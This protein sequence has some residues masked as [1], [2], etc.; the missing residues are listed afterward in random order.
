MGVA[1]GLDWI[2]RYWGKARPRNDQGPDWHPLAYHSLDVAAAMGAMLDARPAWLATVAT[3]CK[4]DPEEARLR[5]ILVAALHDLGKFADNFQQKA[6]A[7]RALLQPTAGLAD[8]NRGHGEIGAELWQAIP[9]A[10]KVSA[11]SAWAFAAFA[12][13]GAP[14][15][16]SDSFADAASEVSVRDA[17]AFTAAMIDLIGAPNQQRARGGEWLVAGL[18]TLADWIGSNQT[19][20]P[21]APPNQALTAYWAYSQERAR[22]AVAD[23]RLVEALPSSSFGLTSILGESAKPSPLQKW[24]EQQTPSSSPQLYIIE[25]LTG[26]GKS[27]A[28]IILAHRLIAAGAAEGLFWAL[29]T[30][31]TANGLYGRLE[32]SYTAL[33]AQGEHPSLVLA[34]GARDIHDGFQASIGRERDAAYGE[35]PHDEQDISAE[36][37]CAAFVA[38]DRKKSFLAEVGVGTID[39]ALLAVLPVRHQSLRLAA[40]SRRVLII[41]EAH[42]YDPYMATELEGLL[43]FQAFNGGSAIVMSATLSMKNRAKLIE[44]CARGLGEAATNQAFPL[45]THVCAGT[46]SEVPQSPARGTQRDL[47]VQRFETPEAVIDALLEKAGQ[48]ACGVYVRNT[49]ADAMQA[50]EALKS[51][52]PEGVH[53]E[54]FHARYAICDRKTVENSTL[55]RFGPNSRPEDRRARILVAT[56]VVEQSLDLDFD[57]MATD[58]CP[59][60][61]IIQRAGRLHRHGHRPPRPAPVLWVVGPEARMDVEA[62]WYARPFPIAKYVYPDVGQLWRTMTLLTAQGGLNFKTGS[63]RDFIEPVFGHQAMDIPTSLMAASDGAEVK[64]MTERSLGHMNLLKFNRFDRQGG[65][66]DSDVRTPTRLGEDTMTLRLARWQ[67]GDLIPWCSSAEG[68]RAWRLSEISVPRRWLEKP[69]YPSEAA[70]KTVRT[71][72]SQWPDRY[73]APLVLVLEPSEEAEIWVGA[74]YDRNERRVDVRYSARFGLE[75]G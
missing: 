31:A 32:R 48:G 71:V 27:E 28:A 1:D 47:P 39:Q 61:L 60:D 21:Y 54:L 49:V 74:W 26:A 43:R 69:I 30:M 8:C 57:Y 59:M 55:A 10:Q 18:V 51:A 46:V 7:L 11:L 33:F 38:E 19:W 14:V 24:A 29:P 66:W 73:E 17:H 34:H 20:F 44:A 25:D 12:H 52:A 6:P 5:L 62:D 58:L 35:K 67:D 64:R 9:K 2:G 40:L 3:H 4:I 36:A 42:A 65:A 72:Q 41:D 75:R 53:V 16:A 70:A 37:S 13:H 63:P 45:V 68:D 56:Q 23:A 50:Y 15:E 22:V